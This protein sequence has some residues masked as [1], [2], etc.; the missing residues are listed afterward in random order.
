MKRL[1]LPLL[2]CVLIASCQTKPIEEMSYTER[3]A[4]AAEIVKRCIDQGVS[5]KNQREMRRCTDIEAQREVYTRRRNQEM[6]DDI[7][8]GIEKG[9]ASYN[10]AANASRPVHCT[11]Q[12]IGTMTT[13]NCY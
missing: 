6:L 3:K 12:T 2:S 13:T 10:A 8:E 11:S 1:A 9:A 7:G 5:P 4:L